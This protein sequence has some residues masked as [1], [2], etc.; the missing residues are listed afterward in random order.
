MEF[1]EEGYRFHQRDSEL[2]TFILRF[3]AE[4][5]L[6]DNG[7]ITECDVYKQEPWVTYG[8]GRH[9]GGEDDRDT[10]IFRYFILPRHEKKKTNDRFCRVMEGGYKD[11]FREALLGEEII[12]VLLEND[13][14]EITCMWNDDYGMINHP[15]NVVENP[16]M[17]VDE[18]EVQIQEAV[19]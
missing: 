14:P 12:K 13:D 19:G 2:F 15:I 8:Y 9:C 5:D 4:K 6:C 18:V 10:N 1:E 11:D 16:T 17:E 7:F 3:I